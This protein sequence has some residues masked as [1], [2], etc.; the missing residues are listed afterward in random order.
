VDL[1]I[2]LKII[3]KISLGDIQNNKAIDLNL[4]ALGILVNNGIDGNS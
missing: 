4:I 2:G 1:L 3:E